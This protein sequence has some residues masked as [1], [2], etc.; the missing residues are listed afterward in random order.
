MSRNALNVLP[1]GNVAH[2]PDNGLGGDIRGKVA[3]HSELVLRER[4]RREWDVNGYA[5]GALNRNG[6]APTQ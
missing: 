6:S 2:H 3:D 5:G 1:S 4:R